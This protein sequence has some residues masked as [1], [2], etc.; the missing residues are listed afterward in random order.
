[1]FYSKIKHTRASCVTVVNQLEWVFCL[2]IALNM[3]LVI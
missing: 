1:L 3:H 2:S